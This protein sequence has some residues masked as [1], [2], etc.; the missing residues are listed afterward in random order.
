MLIYDYHCPVCQ[1]TFEAYVDSSDQKVPCP[2]CNSPTEK[3]LTMPAFILTGVGITSRGTFAKA[4]D[5]PWLDPE[6]LALPDKEL[7]YECG[8]DADVE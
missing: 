1:K 6:L 4:K 2:T 7:N 3:R 8:L 5:G